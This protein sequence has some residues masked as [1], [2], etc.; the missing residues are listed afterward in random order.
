[1][2]KS[3]ET[4]DPFRGLGDFELT[5]ATIV[6][7][8][9]RLAGVTIAKKYTEPK[10]KRT[11]VKKTAK[12]KTAVKRSKRKSKTEPLTITVL[13]PSGNE[14]VLD[15]VPEIKE[16]LLEGW[17]LVEAEDMNAFNELYGEAM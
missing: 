14:Q 16:L 2:V 10:P 17:T 6:R 1:M 13:S 7:G 12:K 3:L 11:P 15:M 4:D 9:T 5:R 8:I